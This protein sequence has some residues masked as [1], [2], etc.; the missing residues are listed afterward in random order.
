MEGAEILFQ[1]ECVDRVLDKMRVKINQVIVTGTD[2]V[3]SF[4]WN[5]SNHAHAGFEVHQI[6]N[7]FETFMVDCLLRKSC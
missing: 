1:V 3:Q 5:T 6:E 4:V 2:K 7:T